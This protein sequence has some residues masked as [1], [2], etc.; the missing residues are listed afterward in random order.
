VSPHS[1]ETLILIGLCALHST[2]IPD[3]V[4]YLPGP[5]RNTFI[6]SIGQGIEN[7]VD[8]AD[9]AATQVYLK[10]NY[11][12]I[13]RP[14]DS[15]PED[16]LV[17]GFSGTSLLPYVTSRP[18]VF[19][20]IATEV[21]S[22]QVRTDVMAKAGAWPRDPVDTRLLD[23]VNSLTGSINPTSPPGGFP[24]YSGTPRDMATYD[25]DYDG[26]PNTWEE[27]CGLDPSGS[28]DGAQTA[29]NGYTNLENFL[30]KLAG[31][32]IP[33]GDCGGLGGS[34]PTSPFKQT[35]RIQVNNS[36]SSVNVRSCAS[37]SCS[38]VGTQPD[39]SLGAIT[40]ASPTTA[41]GFTWHQVDFASGA[42]GYVA[43]DFLVFAGDL[44]RDATVNSLDW[45]SMN[46]A[47]FTNSTT[48]DINKDG[49]VNSIDFG[50]LN[51]NWGLSS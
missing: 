31:D 23:E 15:Y 47:W 41:D 10:G 17:K 14:N 3:N 43:E 30:N 49:L 33:M 37:T 51:K 48:A 7:D 34:T 25:S 28:L 35:D 16:S 32:T 13:L 2:I 29:P 6:Q 44:N 18:S 40:S 45:S 4:Y 24:T 26:M 27:N 1:Q 22:Q 20:G 9:H 21:D 8:P 36:G 11:D 38:I 50:I 39:R 12:K 5:N 42:D 19:V 46:S